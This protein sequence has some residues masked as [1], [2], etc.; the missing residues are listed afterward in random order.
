MGGDRIFYFLDFGHVEFVLS[1]ATG[2]PLQDWYLERFPS[3]GLMVKT[4]HLGRVFVSATAI[5]FDLVFV[6]R[7]PD[8]ASDGDTTYAIR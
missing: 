6:S 3:G 4:T 7:A 8:S 1:A 2:D 5:D